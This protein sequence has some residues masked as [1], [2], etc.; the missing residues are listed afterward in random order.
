MS[1]ITRV[2]QLE[3]FFNFKD[4]EFRYKC[5]AD[6]PIWHTENISSVARSL[7][8]AAA[9]VANVADS[10]GVKELSAV[11]GLINNDLKLLQH[12]L[13]VDYDAEAEAVEFD[14]LDL[15]NDED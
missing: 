8:T 9:I 2:Q 3:S 10:V 5:E 11:F 13:K 1:R 12:L 4:G 6:C 15:D 7:H 14:D